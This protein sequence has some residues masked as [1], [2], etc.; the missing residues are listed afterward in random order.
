MTPEEIR[1]IRESL[2]WGPVQTARVLGIP[3]RTF[4]DAEDGT[5]RL[6][7]SAVRLLRLA[8]RYPAVRAELE[9][10]AGE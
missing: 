2:G 9:R 8:T 5:R 4:H 1:T 3:Y 10:M 6:H 7:P